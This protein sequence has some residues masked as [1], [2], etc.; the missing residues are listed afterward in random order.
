MLCLLCGSTDKDS[1][2][3]AGDHLQYRRPG[4]N[5]WVEKIP[6][7]R[8]WQPTPGFLPGQSHGQRSLVGDSP[9][10]CKESDTPVATKHTHLVASRVLN[11]LCTWST[12]NRV[13][14]GLGIQHMNL[15]GHS[16]V[17]NRLICVSTNSQAKALTSRASECNLI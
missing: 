10:G 17:L 3:N 14:W 13:T 9:Q 7:R 1:I 4:F 6:W 5:S 12:P 15:G 2:C 11:Y 8:K 16:S